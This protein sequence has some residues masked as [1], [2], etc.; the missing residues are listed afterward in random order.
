MVYGCE[1][2]QERQEAGRLENLEAAKA[3]FVQA[4][5]A[6]YAAWNARLPEGICHHLEKKRAT[7]GN[8]FFYVTVATSFTKGRVEITVGDIKF[9]DDQA[10]G[11]LDYIVEDNKSSRAPTQDEYRAF[12]TLFFQSVEA[13]I[14]PA[15]VVYRDQPGQE[16]ESR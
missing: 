2:M 15:F 6:N 3:R 4:N 12:T 11:S 9:L 7:N 10:D 13:C 14:P 16:G 5:R 8:G 1:A